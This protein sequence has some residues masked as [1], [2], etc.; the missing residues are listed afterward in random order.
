MKLFKLITLVILT[1]SFITLGGCGYT[2]KIVS[3][4]KLDTTSQNNQLKNID[5]IGRV[6]ESKGV[7]VTITNNSNQPFKTPYPT[8][9]EVFASNSNGIVHSLYGPHYDLPD[10]INPGK[11]VTYF[12]YVPD[13]WESSDVKRIFLRWSGSEVRLK[14]IDL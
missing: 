3:T 4:H 14:R 12:R 11:Y 13:G 9:F 6:T 7:E 8:L 10:Y 2:S 5:I 1:S